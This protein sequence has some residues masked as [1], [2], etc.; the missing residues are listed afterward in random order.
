MSLPMPDQVDLYCQWALFYQ[1]L[2]WSVVPVRPSEKI[3]AV[4]WA[5]YQTAPASREQIGE[6]WEGPFRGFSVG[7][8]QG[9]A[10]GTFV[11][12]IDDHELE[13]RNGS[14]ALRELERRNGPLPD[15][16][17]AITGSG[18]R[19]LFFRH[20]G[21]GVRIRTVKDIAGR[22]I[23]VRGDG[24]FV[25]AA[26]SLHLS[27]RHY[28]WE[29]DHH[30]PDVM[31]VQAPGWLIEIVQE[32]G[33][34]QPIR[35]SG[36]SDGGIVTDAFNRVIDGREGYMVEVIAA[37]L[38]SFVREHRRA[39]DASD[40]FQHAWPIYEQRARSRGESLEADGRGQTAFR[41]KIDY[42]LKRFRDGKIRGLESV[43]DVL[44]DAA[45]GD[46]WSQLGTTTPVTE[47]SGAPPLLRATALGPLVIDELPRREWVVTGRLMRKF[48]S[49]LYGPG[50]L[51]KSS[52]TMQEAISVALGLP[53]NGDGFT[54][55]ESGRVWIYNNEDPLDELRR[56]LG[57]I[58]LNWGIEPRKLEGRVFLD[59]G[60]DRRLIIATKQDG[61]VVVTPDVD[62]LIEEIR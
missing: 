57:A 54:V 9:A 35:E 45:A 12:D 4:Q 49:V 5:A 38:G 26:P 34:N 11:I 24:G 61:I 23:D 13:G 18:G 25:V 3:P 17:E 43:E 28:A 52:F 2:G 41:D 44:I 47:G 50:G 10:A 55:K 36:A 60:L 39:P 1:T 31:P 27:G 58:C 51:N 14:E 62:G 59:S 16:A 37:A 53:L 7:L 30:P 33:T 21:D 29:V 20:P 40:L 22:G 6:W 15:T 56:R 42:T 46:D 19:H 32:S 8:I 48:V